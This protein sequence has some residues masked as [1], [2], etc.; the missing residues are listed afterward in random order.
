MS[1]KMTPLQQRRRRHLRV[2]RKVVGTAQR[3]RLCV[4]KS[5]KHIYAQLIDDDAGRTLAA[6]SS[7]EPAVAGGLKSGGNVEAAR[8]V[9]AALA[10]RA[11]EKGLKQV[12]FDRAGWPYWG[13]LQALAE[14]AREG[15]L[16]F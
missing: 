13:K 5:L 4:F 12:V 7:R 16:E 3:P 10:A 2:R 8:V 1:P 6:A 14:A 11:L 9:G 15:G